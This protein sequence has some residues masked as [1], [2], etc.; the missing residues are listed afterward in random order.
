VPWQ[1]HGL[2]LRL[3]D[4][5]EPVRF[6]PKAAELARRGCGA[7]AGARF[8]ALLRHTGK[9]RLA[10][11]GPRCFSRQRRTTVRLAI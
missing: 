6:A 7:D 8:T 11:Y 10:F 1:V 3:E 5:G 2:A 9:L 4:G